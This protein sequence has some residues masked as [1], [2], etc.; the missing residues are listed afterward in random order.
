MNVVNTT[1]ITNSDRICIFRDGDSTELL[2]PQYKLGPVTFNRTDRPVNANQGNPAA[3]VLDPIIDG[4][5]LTRVLMDG[6]S[7]LNLL[8]QDTVR[9]MGIDHSVIK[10]TKA[11]FRGIIPGVEASCTGSIALEVVFGSPDNYRAEELIFDI[12]P[13]RSDYQA[14]LG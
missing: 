10:P 1:Q 14:L 11:T 8:Y 13:F 3:L 12:V 4:F 2:V 5:H 9:K 7:S 6:G